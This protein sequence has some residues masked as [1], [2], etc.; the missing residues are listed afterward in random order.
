MSK[1]ITRFAPSP[2]GELHIGGART[3]LFNYLYAKNN[4]GKFLLRIEDTDRARS[5]Q[6]NVDIIL[7][8]LKWLGLEWDG[9][10]V[11]QFKKQVRHI[12]IADDLMRNGHAYR[13]FCG[14][15][16][17][18]AVKKANN[19]VFHSPYRDDKFSIYNGNKPFSVR[20][21]IPDVEKGRIWVNDDVQGSIKWHQKVF[22]DFV[23]V[24]SDGLPTYM[25]AVVVDDY[26]MKITNVIR[27]NDHLNNTAKQIMIYCAMGWNIPH[28]AHIPLIHGPDGSKLSKRHGALGVHA[29]EKMGYLAKGIN[30]YL[31]RLGWAKGDNEF[32]NMD[33]AIEWFDFKGI[34]KSPARLDFKKLDSVNAYHMK[35]SNTH[36]LFKHLMNIMTNADRKHVED[37]K[38]QPAVITAID[39]MKHKSANLE[40][41]YENLLFVV[42]EHKIEVDVY[43]PFEDNSKLKVTMFDCGEFL[44]KIDNWTLD[45][46]DEVIRKAVELNDVK[47]GTMSKVIRAALSTHKKS[48]GIF[49]MIHS[50]G[51]REASNRLSATFDHISSDG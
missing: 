27:G 6:D 44:L 2:S 29:Y 16:E 23:I 7:N 45:K 8:G 48:P 21:R 37:N 11:S 41:L 49:E 17:I 34:S 4:G 3:A 35:E 22:E 40:K 15:D 26:D 18:E 50:L 24:R 32:F 1:V 31:T 42:R 20:F 43:Q 9:Q 28:M 36:F 46:V 19:G 30:N 13:C 5:T 33:Q 14:P 47:F 39:H 10:P 38:L 12:K 51:K 25:L